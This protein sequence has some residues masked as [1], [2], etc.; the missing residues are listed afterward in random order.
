MTSKYEPLNKHL[1]TLSGEYV[2]M[3]FR[4]IEK[5]LG[6][7]LAKSAYRHR[8]GGAIIRTIA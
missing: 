8:P 2:H 5:V 3:S 1:N 4:E 6:F 7:G